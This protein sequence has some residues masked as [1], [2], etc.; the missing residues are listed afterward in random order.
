[1]SAK[2]KGCRGRGMRIGE[3]E[4]QVTTYKVRTAQYICA[5]SNSLVI[6]IME[7]TILMIFMVY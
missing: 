7:R 2:V 1:M 5:F 4:G 6:G 3:G